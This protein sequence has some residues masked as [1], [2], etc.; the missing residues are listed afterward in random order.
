MPVEI[1]GRIYYRIASLPDYLLTKT[2]SVY[3]LLKYYY[4]VTVI[5]SYLNLNAE[6][7]INATA[8]KKVGFCILNE[9]MAYEGE[10]CAMD[11]LWYSKSRNQ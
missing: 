8:P 1:N 11:R 7:L 6:E 10:N 5:C 3:I 4:S 2:F 9:I